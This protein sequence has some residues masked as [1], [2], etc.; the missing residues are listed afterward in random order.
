MATIPDK[1]IKVETP[2]SASDS[3]Y[4]E[5]EFMLSWY[6]RDG[7]FYTQLFTDWREDQDVNARA[8]NLSDK[9]KI[10]NIILS[11][12]RGVRLTIEEVTLNDLKIL[13]SVLVA[14]NIIR[15]FKDGTTENIGIKGNSQVFKQSD[16]RYNLVF[17]IVQYEKALVK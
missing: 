14:K 7:S 13:S 2:K 6:G 12:E 11:E 9:T 10:Q 8:L 17:D 5:F 15:T 16:G 1:I 3:N 4:E